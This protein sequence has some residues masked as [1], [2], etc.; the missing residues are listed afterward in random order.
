MATRSGICI[1]YY[2]APGWIK[3]EITYKE[4]FIKKTIRQYESF[5][6]KLRLWE[7][8]S[9]KLSFS[10]FWNIQIIL[11]CG[12]Q[13]Y[14]LIVTKKQIYCSASVLKIDFN[15]LS[16]LQWIISGFRRQIGANFS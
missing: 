10:A 5:Y 4:E 14:G 1:W 16:F 8:Q 3:F 15:I 12:T 2:K 6:I 13:I 11:I 9:L 7:T